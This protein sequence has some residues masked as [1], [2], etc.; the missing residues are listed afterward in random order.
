MT[1]Q[2]ETDSRYAWFRLCVTV[3]VAVIANAGM[4]A[5]IVI[6]PAVEAEFG[7][8]RA[9]ASM[10]Y[11]LN[12]IGFALGN[13]AIGR[14]LDRFGVA[15]SLILAALGI[16]AG[17]VLAI[18]SHS[19]VMLSIAQLIVGLASA[20][21]FGP[22]IADISHWFVRRRGIAVALVASGNYLSGA[23]WPML[24]AGVLASDGWRAAY[25]VLAVVTFAGV[26]PLAFLLR[27]ATSDATRDAAQL[28]STLNAQ[29][30]GVS[31]RVLAYLLGFA[32]ISC[33]V[34]MSMPQVHIVSLCV[35][36]GFGPVAGA[37]MLS[38]MLLGGVGSRIVSGL[39]ADRLGG[40]RTLLIGSTLQC[41]ALF[42]YLPAGGLISLYI[43]SL[44]FGLSQGGIVPSY[45]LIVREYM[46]AKEAGARV[47]FVLMATIMGMALGGWMSGQIYV[48]T[49]SYEWAFINGIIWNGFNIAIMLWLL[50][51]STPRGPRITSAPAPQPA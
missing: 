2:T 7:A 25:T 45:A 41:L 37:E 50:L 14:A 24:L 40:V 36:M 10:P 23:I 38:L 4:W 22:L 35:D 28:A 21:G 49:G 46:P 44:V 6:M 15:V 33:C 20:V 48:W 1:D 12:M 9:A 13:F 18:L 39:L 8:S 42:L 26:I 32:G 34:A 19:I 16:V 47:G 17:L 11:T 31:P 5:I 30:S 51:R 43:V 3:L 27:R 29:S